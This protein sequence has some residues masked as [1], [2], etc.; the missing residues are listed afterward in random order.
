MSLPLAEHVE[1]WT[2]LIKKER[3]A[4]LDQFNALLSDQSLA[5]L[6]AAGT[7]LAR[8]HVKESR[9]ALGG[10]TIVQFGKKNDRPLPAHKFSPGGPICIAH[11]ADHLTP[12]FDGV[13]SNV[14]E[15]S[16]GLCF[17]R[18]QKIEELKVPRGTFAILPRIYETT[19]QRLMQ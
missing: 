8:L 18:S 4:E 15:D 10:R 1:K 6:C 2:S 11:T 7:C 16:I 5:E 13:V 19:F 9:S 12:L 17:D 3:Q 14:S